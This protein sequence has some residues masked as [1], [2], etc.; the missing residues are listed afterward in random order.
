M[1]ILI[2]TFAAGLLFALGL[3]VS[4]MTQPE[5]V[6]GFLDVRAWDPA[7]LFVMAGAATTYMLLFP[8]VTRRARPILA[9]RFDVPTSR[10]LTPRLVVGAAM[11]GVGWGLAGYCP[12][13]A[14]VSLPSGMS[15]VVVFI[16]AMGAGM[17]AFDRFNRIRSTHP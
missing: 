10:D 2:T 4:G 14:I 3:G 16:A 12:G 5:K 7:L 6:I 1:K 11:F 15:S 17:F 8:L 9:E 13:P